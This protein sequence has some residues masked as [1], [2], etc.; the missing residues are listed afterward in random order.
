MRNFLLKAEREEKEY[1]KN[2]KSFIKCKNSTSKF[3][4][5]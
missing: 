2:Q 1:G 5:K 3:L 4:E